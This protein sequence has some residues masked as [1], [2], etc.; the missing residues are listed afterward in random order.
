MKKFFARIGERIR[1]RSANHIPFRYRLRNKTEGIVTGMEYK[2]WIYKLLYAA[3]L[4][5][6]LAAVLTAVIPVL[7][8][9]LAGFKD[10]QDVFKAPFTFWP[11][12]I[13][14]GK[15]AEVW[16]TVG[17]TRYFLNTL[18]LVV[19]SVICAVFF[20]GLLAYAVSIV[21]PSGHK[22]VYGLIMAS[23]MIPAVASLVP[24]YANINKL[25]LT[26][27]A[28]FVPLCLLY[29][30]NSYYFMMIKNYFDTIPESLIESARIDGA[31]N[32]RI[33]FSMVL[34]LSRPIMGVVSIFAMTAAWADFLLPYLLL[35]DQD[36]YTAMVVI[37]NLRSSMANMADFGIDKYLIAVAI[38]ILPQIVLFA[39]F[40]R[41]IMGTG[42]TS[43]IKG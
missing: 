17:F 12:S 14:L 2:K 42:A 13:D 31:G 6:L 33:F 37:Y 23:Y 20:N 32:M 38:T 34:P 30:A 29:G 8:L 7:W 25:G 3:I 11:K 40:Q 35:Q 15:I 43:G 39:V 22:V 41:Q 5:V 36:L 27:Y 4:L 19:G 24:L 26:G 21:K 10:A 9:F 28:T 18:L 1:K 16:K